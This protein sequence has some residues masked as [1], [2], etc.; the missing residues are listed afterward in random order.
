MKKRIAAISAVLMAAA[1]LSFGNGLNLNSIGARALAMGGAF[2]GLAD[3][4]S[5]LF[6]N[7]AGLSFFKAKT[8]GFYGSDIIPSGRYSLTLPAPVAAAL[9]V[10]PAVVDAKTQTKHY[11]GAMF[12]YVHPI[13]EKL[14]AG[15][16]VFQPAGLGAAWP[17]ADLAFISGNRKDIEWMSKV[18]LITF[19]PTL[20]YKVNDKLSFGA[21]LNI[22]Y[23]IF[24]IGTYAGRLDPPLVPV[25]VDLGQ[26]EESETGW[27]VGATFSALF[28]PSDLF[29]LGLTV[30]TPVT[31]NFSGEARISNLGFLGLAGQ[32]RMEREVKWPLWVGGGVAFRPMDKLTLTA[33]IQFT[34]WK[35]ID[36]IETTYTDPIWTQIMTAAGKTEMPMHWENRMQVRVG[37]EYALKD[38]FALRAGYYNDPAPAPD[39][40]M[41]ILLPNYDFNAFCLGVGYSLGAL[42]LD[43][44]VEYL[45]GKTRDI[46]VLKAFT[47]PTIPNPAY[48][49]AYAEAQPGKYEMKILAPAIMVT[50]RF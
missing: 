17:S 31:V 50:Y 7:P 16:G 25:S 49:P 22:D 29:S 12:G 35:V 34:D 48:D 1:P 11:L 33:D 27:G 8:F 41:N 19:A 38:G 44:G 36:V 43:F 6:W 45:F 23:G 47:H 15:F 40:T 32:S 9:S 26:Y 37:A 28:K 10:N 42:Q 21:Q 30:R 39:R 20:A 46:N 4:F 14:V 2:I 24:N 5:A 18:G 13:S 3:D